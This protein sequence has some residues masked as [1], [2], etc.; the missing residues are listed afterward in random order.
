MDI[1]WND[2]PQLISALSLLFYIITH[3]STNI[4]SF[5]FIFRIL[6]CLPDPYPSPSLIPPLNVLYPLSNITRI[7]ASIPYPSLCFPSLLLFLKS[8]IAVHRYERGWS[9]ESESGWL[10]SFSHLTL[11]QPV[12]IH[13]IPSH[14]S[15]IP[16]HIILS[17]PIPVSLHPG[18]S[19]LIIL[20]QLNLFQS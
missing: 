8:M 18:M 19:V 11:S 5:H 16:F 6:S 17:H 4:V 15:I 10:L 3:A 14:Y 2:A 12:F 9:D 20:K 7:S 1:P 13:T